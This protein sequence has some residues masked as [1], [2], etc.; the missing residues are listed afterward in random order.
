MID[1]D[2]LTLAGAAATGGWY[3]SASSAAAA[4]AAVTI[5]T[6]APPA[7]FSTTPVSGVTV[8][9]SGDVALQNA[10]GTATG[11]SIVLAND[12]SAAGN[13]FLEAT[14]AGSTIASSGGTIGLAGGSLSLF[15]TAG[16]GTSASGIT[17]SDTSAL[18]L[19][20]ETTTGGV[21]LSASDP[22]RVTVGHAAA[23]P[24]FFANG[25]SGLESLA[26]SSSGDVALQN[27][28][29]SIS[30]ATTIDLASAGSVYLEADG[31]G[32][33]ITA[34]GGTIDL[35]GGGL[36][37]V[38]GAGVGTASAPVRVV[39]G[40]ALTIAGATGTGGWYVS[41][42]SPAAA[43]AAVTV[44]ALTPPAFF[45]TTP[46]TGVTVA[47]GGDVALQN[48]GGTA[49]GGSIVLAD[50][51]DLSG[52]AG[53]NVFL[54]ADGAAATIAASGGSIRLDG[55]NLAL[56]AQGGI[57]TSAAPIVTSDAGPLTVAASTLA[58]GVFL[59]DASPV[60]AGAAVTV[61]QVA[62]PGFFATPLV[63]GIASP[64]GGNVTLANAGG[65]ST[66]GA[67][68]LADPLTLNSATGTLTL[69]ATGPIS[70]TGGAITANLLT[71]SAGGSASLA[72]NN[73]I[74]NLGAVTVS[75]TGDGD[76][77]LQDTS[78]L[79]LVG[80]ASVANGAIAIATTGTMTVAG[81]LAFTSTGHVGLGSAGFNEA[82]SFTI[83][84]A[85][86][87]IVDA[88]GLTAV[89]LDAITV[90]NSSQ[91]SS[92][93]LGPGVS[94][95]PVISFGGFDAAG[96]TLLISVDNGSVTGNVMVAGL[97]ISGSGDTIDLFGS[98]A[99]VSNEFAAI[100]AVRAQGPDNDDRFN[101]CAIGS[102]ACVVEPILVP[103]IP[104]S[105]DNVD[106]LTLPAPLD[107]LDIDRLNTGNE[108]DL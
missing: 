50:N 1:S 47:T 102:P 91:A 57:G 105:L 103:V 4:G 24:S 99:G 43:G 55:T 75:A 87:V 54:E 68:V 98:I 48:L 65:S 63:T 28:S 107:P 85:P 96:S 35:A 62:T 12:A 6:V 45:A 20:A 61:G 90:T 58:G 10:G 56:I 7:F 71:L 74:A 29:G 66:G 89:Q 86:A 37:L 17:V 78:N 40:S 73:A 36:S 69:A 27:T 31:A 88:T 5:G 42:S 30:L 101:S 93:P 14:G 72:M 19:A 59:S 33:R 16:I 97:G 21:Y 100:L 67:I 53:G 80:N 13:L 82:G 83:S 34:S 108:D 95:G 22:V 18:T 79:A 52:D 94:G 3:V 9:T 76:F 38:A 70:Q 60:A 84:G 44:G 39:D 106:F 46:V 23:A 26:S 11:G 92:L 32:A 64:N 2:A 25:A 104:P 81:S 77:V 41:V 51:I 8:A 49:S 15:A